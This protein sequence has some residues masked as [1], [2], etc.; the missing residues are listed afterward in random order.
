MILKK[1]NNIDK[2]ISNNNLDEDFNDS[3]FNDDLDDNIDNFDNDFNDDWDMGSNNIPMEKHSELLKQLTNFEP[4]LKKKF[5]EWLALSWDEKQNKYIKNPLLEPIMNIKCANWLISFISTYARQNN[6]ITDIGQD[7][8]N[9]IRE[10]I[11]ETLWS[12]IGLRAKEFG[13]DNYGDVQ[14]ICTEVQHTIELVLMGAGD[15]K[16]NQLLRDTH[17]E[18]THTQPLNYDNQKPKDTTW[19]KRIFGGD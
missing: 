15:G 8:F 10:D 3:N 11:I 9:Y 16:Y 19:F 2:D 4:F 14:R 6:I 18:T 12:N 5:N 1:R 13:I 7:D 17:K